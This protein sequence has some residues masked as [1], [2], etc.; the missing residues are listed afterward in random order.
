MAVTITNTFN[1]VVALQKPLVLTASST[2]TSEPKFRYVMTVDVN[3]VEV[4]KVKQQA[5][6]NDYVHFDLYQII[7][8]YFETKYLDGGN[9]IHKIITTVDGDDT[10]LFIELNV[11]EE[12]ATSATTDPTEYPSTGNDT[13]SFLAINSTFQFTDGVTPTL[14]GVYE[15]NN[16]TTEIQWLTNM[17]TRLKTRA[18][19]YQTAAILASDFRGAVSTSLRYSITFYEADGTQI[20]TANITRTTI[21]MANFV[22]TKSAVNAGVLYQFI[23]IGYQ[24]LEDQSFNT[25]IRPSTQA[26]LAYYTINIFDNSGD[27]ITKTYRFDIAECSRYTP[28]QLAWVNSLGAWDYYTFELASLKKLNIQRETFRKPFGNWGAGATYTYSQYESGDT[29]YKIEADKQYT[30][31][32]DWLN[33]LDFEWLQ[34]LLMSKEVQFVNE[35]GDFTPVIITD[36]D[37]EFKQ[38]VN[39][40]LNNLQL[41]FKL[42]HKIK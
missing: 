36:T 12:Y 29:I 22:A 20:S 31:N 5:N 18:G 23:P 27:Y 34:E 30:V 21:G 16:D 8:D 7:K 35:N 38:D 1:D 14:A 4:V 19:E 13:D 24:N 3:S 33:D 37:Y 39:N 9:E 11:Y 15:F 2:N 26:N 25:S 6:Q 40:K 41:T 10:A 17:P 42:G 32:S 28:I